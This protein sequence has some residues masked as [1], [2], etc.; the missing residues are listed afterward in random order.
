MEPNNL[1][2]WGRVELSYLIILTHHNLIICCVVGSGSIPQH[3][4]FP[5]EKATTTMISITMQEKISQD[6]GILK[7]LN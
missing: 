2:L 3:L 1:C 7:K 6:L 4:F 5:T